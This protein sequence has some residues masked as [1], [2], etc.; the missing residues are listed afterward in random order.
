MTLHSL[1]LAGNGKIL[2]QFFDCTGMSIFKFGSSKSSIEGDV[3]S[4]LLESKPRE[5]DISWN[6]YRLYSTFRT[7]AMWN[8]VLVQYRRWRHTF[9]N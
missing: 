2:R 4:R 8:P 6:D 9:V 1:P 7:V 3:K 5:L